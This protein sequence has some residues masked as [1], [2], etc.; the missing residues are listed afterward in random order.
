MT[1]RTTAGFIC[2][3]AAASLINEASCGSAIGSQSICA[4]CVRATGDSEGRGAVKNDPLVF[5]IGC[6]L[7]RAAPRWKAA[8]PHGF[9]RQDRAR[10]ALCI[11]P[12]KGVR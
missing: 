5:S 11:Q 6:G 8:W 4:F 12:Q 9:A 2:S 1:A 10:F 7:T 3:R